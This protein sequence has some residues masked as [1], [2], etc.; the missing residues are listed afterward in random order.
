MLLY[1]G[2][3]DYINLK[4]SALAIYVTVNMFQHN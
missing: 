2:I 3:L 1:S 4:K